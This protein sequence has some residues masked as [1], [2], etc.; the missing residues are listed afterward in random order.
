ML[1]LSGERTKIDPLDR[2]L[3][4]LAPLADAEREAAHRLLS[5]NPRLHSARRDIVREGDA[6]RAAHVLLEGWACRY[7]ALA[8]GRRQILS[9]L[10]PGDIFDL[11]CFA[12]RRM[13]H[14]LGAITAVKAAQLGRS[15][16]DRLM[17]MPAVAAALWRSELIAA[18]ILRE[19]MLNVG[20]RAAY[21]RVAHLICEIF[22]RMGA[23]GLV[24][25]GVCDFPLTQTDIADAG[26]LTSVHVNRMMQALRAEGLIAL[27]GKRLSIP[28]LPRL[29]K[30]GLF[31]PDYLH[32]DHADGPSRANG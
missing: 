5:A 32:L 26:G 18:S 12:L 2:R 6:P 17:E 24:V 19:W 13:D 27:Q 8:D 3:A 22:Y 14:S 9:F 1:N 28:D 16:L 23:A 10:I 15:E 29:M 25:D 21:E 7:K 30:A 11:N 4:A 31:R 20:Q